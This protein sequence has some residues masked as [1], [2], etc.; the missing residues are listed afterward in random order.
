M[1]ERANILTNERINR[2]LL[3]PVL[4]TSWR[5]YAV[6][7]ALLGFGGDGQTAA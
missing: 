2:D 7:A 3:A 5:F 6:V 4:T 1:E